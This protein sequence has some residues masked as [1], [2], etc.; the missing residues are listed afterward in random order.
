MEK[1]PKNKWLQFEVSGARIYTG[2]PPPDK[3]LGPI[4]VY[5]PEMQERTK[6][7][8]PRR[9]ALVDGKFKI[10]SSRAAAKLPL[11]GDIPKAKKPILKVSHYI[12]AAAA[13][14]GAAAVY[15]LN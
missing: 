8:N 12:A 4:L 14:A 11:R 1:E 5:T 15:F 10:L 2:S 3:S 6:R 13:G 9:F 7:I